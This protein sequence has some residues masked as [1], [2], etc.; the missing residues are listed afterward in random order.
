MVHHHNQHEHNRLS[1]RN[2]LDGGRR[3]NNTY[4]TIFGKNKTNTPQM[5]IADGHCL[6]RAIAKRLEMHP[7]Y[8]V[9]LIINQIKTILRYDPRGLSNEAHV[10]TYINNQT[11][12]IKQTMRT[13]INKMIKFTASHFIYAQTNRNTHRNASNSTY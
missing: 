4:T 5:L 9:H 8:L 6:R 11:N 1:H 7:G 10:N 12:N 3:H 2:N 13:Y